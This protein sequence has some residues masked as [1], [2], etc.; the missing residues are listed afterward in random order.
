MKITISLS[1]IA[2]L[3]ALPVESQV[4]PYRQE[5]VVSRQCLSEDE[6]ADQSRLDLSTLGRIANNLINGTGGAIIAIRTKNN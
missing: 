2:F 6:V 4:L 5:A 1:F 3:C